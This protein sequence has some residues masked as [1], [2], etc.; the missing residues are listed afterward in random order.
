MSDKEVKSNLNVDKD[1]DVGGVSGEQA[2]EAQAV[3]ADTAK[4]NAELAER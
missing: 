1:K 3:A 2:A 4:A